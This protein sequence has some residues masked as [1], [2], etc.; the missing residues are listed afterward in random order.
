MIFSGAGSLRQAG[1]ESPAKNTDL[2]SPQKW[3]Q[4][5]EC[6]S[7]NHWLQCGLMGLSF[8]GGYPVPKAGMSSPYNLSI[9]L[10][11]LLFLPL[12]SLSL[13]SSL[14]SP[15]LPPFPSP[16]PS[17]CICI[18]CFVFEK[19]PSS[20]TC[21]YILMEARCQPWVCHSSGATY[22]GVFCLLDFLGLFIFEYMHAYMRPGWV[23]LDHLELQL[24]M[25]G[26]IIFRFWEPNLGLL[27]EEQVPLSEEP[28]LQHPSCIYFEVVCFSL[29]C[30]LPI[31]IGWLSIE[32]QE[33]A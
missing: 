4:I 16:L 29:A 12:L 9:S 11:L 31:K 28:F 24:W 7:R 6:R 20:C 33:F 30:S 2:G 27:R 10:S 32:P 21:M 18:F 5:P 1:Q 15:F 23:G 13:S 14:F 22:L 3:L 19:I 26:A 25:V 17:L 8:K